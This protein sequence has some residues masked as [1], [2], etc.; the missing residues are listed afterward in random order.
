MI[1]TKSLFKK[2]NDWSFKMYSMF[3][4]RFLLIILLLFGG[5]S[6]LHTAQAQEVL[7]IEEAVQ[8]GLE[9]NYSIRIS[10]NN[11]EI[12]ENNFSLG[13]AGFFP[14]IFADVMKSRSIEDS[15]TVFADGNI[16][17]RSDEGAESTT[18]S[19]GVRL[20][21]TI[22]D[23][24]QMFTSYNRLQHLR[25]MGEDQ[26]R[27]TIEQT[28]ADITNVYYNIVL[29]KKAV[30]VLENTLEVSQE[31]IRIAETKKDLGSGSEYDL[32]QARADLNAD[33]AALIRQEVQLANAR[34]LLNELLARD[35]NEQ[36]DV[37]EDID[38]QQ[39]MKYVQLEQKM[40]ADNTVL[41]IARINQDVAK[42]EIREIQGERYPEVVINLGYNY[43]KNESGSGFIEFSR[44][45]GLNYGLTARVD[46][47][48]GF[49]INRR[50]E[51]ARINLKNQ[52]LELEQQ[53]KE[54]EGNLSSEYQN[55]T[56][57]LKL[58][59]LESQNMEYARRS[60]DIALERF[61]L[62][63]ITSVELREAQR[64]LIAAEN[65]LIQAQF[66]AKMAETELLRISGQLTEKVR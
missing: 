32:L 39:Q 3:S 23:G 22:F 4:Y 31:R 46:L 10:G 59:D 36:F 51:N 45:N 61:Q 60:L 8:I 66:E 13:N 17:N 2:L 54:L 37:N 21:W 62:G 50:V 48:N 40:M 19:A 58:V 1:L 42:L 25:D 34:I 5:V 20:D 41:G 63:T 56:N 43:N 30:A 55:Y 53:R 28:I 7:T 57:A 16:P 12:S 15:E 38:L 11:A 26:F 18:T 24:L 27:L 52:E 6:A 35:I 14:L 64:T 47:F 33:S 9:N 44:S 65:R 29:Q 49:D